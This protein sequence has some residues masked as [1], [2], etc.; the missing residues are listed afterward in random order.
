[1]MILC[2]KIMVAMEV[3]DWWRWWWWML[4]TMRVETTGE[5][6]QAI[7]AIIGVTFDLD[8][9]CRLVISGITDDRWR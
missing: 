1:M 4:N 6:Q 9:R 2:Y 8:D 3:D 7:I 5:W